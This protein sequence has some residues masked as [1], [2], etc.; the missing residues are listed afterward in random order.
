MREV[1]ID[2]WW[3]VALPLMRQNW[4][5]TGFDFD[6]APDR[7][8]YVVGQRA[9]FLI[10]LG[11]FAGGNLVGYST[12]TLAPHPFNPRVRV[13][14]SDALFVAP[15]HRGG[16]LPGRLVVGTERLARERGALRMAWHTRA[17]TPFAEVLR[18]RGYRDADTVVMRE[19]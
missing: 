7:G 12:A 17:G 1:N 15:S 3:D 9:G 10:A 18:A 11:A 4:R 13:C 5:E 19:L 8:M 6:F 14:M 16:L 2:D